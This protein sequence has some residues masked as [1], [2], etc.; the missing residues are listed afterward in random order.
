MQIR[1]DNIKVPRDG[2]SRVFRHFSR[3][4][5]THNTCCRKANVKLTLSGRVVDLRRKRVCTRDPRKGKTIFA[6]R[7]R[8]NGR[9][10]GPSR[11]SFCVNK[12]AIDIPRTR[13]IS[14][15]TNGRDRRRGRRP[16]SSSLPA[17]LVMRSGGSLYGVLGLRLRSGFGV[18]VTGSNI[19]KLGGMRLCRPSVMI[20]S[21]VVPGVSK[22]RVLRHVHG[23]FRVDRV[24]IVVLATGNGS[25]TGAG[26]VD[27]KTGTCV[28]GP[29]D[30]SCLMTHVRRL[31][32][33]HGLFHRH[34]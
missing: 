29:F 9:R 6:V 12:R 2:L 23:S 15:S 19:R 10:C 8:L 7:L 3:T 14:T 28:V 1:S 21:R 5:G 33:R 32:G 4:S 11:I 31:L 22:V 24:P 34:M 30:G 13:S 25:R 16:I 26:T 27:V 18:C 20:A 17:I